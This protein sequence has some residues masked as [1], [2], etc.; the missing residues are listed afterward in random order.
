[1]KLSRE[2]VTFL[3]KAVTD[4]LLKEKCLEGAAKAEELVRKIDAIIYEE[5]MVE[6]RLNAEVDRILK[7][8]EGEIEKGNVDYRK[9]FQMV[10]N[11]LVKERGIVL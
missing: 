5:L 8:H 9:M 4:G 2:R 11:Q 1:M 3:A 6:D 10:K 7:T